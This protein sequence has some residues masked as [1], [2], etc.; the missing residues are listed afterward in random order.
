MVLMCMM[1]TL[2]FIPGGSVCDNR[3]RFPG[4][5]AA[6]AKLA[7]AAGHALVVFL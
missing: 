6:G 4:A 3:N 1:S 2:E 5:G 7:L